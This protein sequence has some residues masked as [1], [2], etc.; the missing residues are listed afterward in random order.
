MWV[1]MGGLYIAIIVALFL[2]WM[3]EMDRRLPPREVATAETRE[4]S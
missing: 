4:P 1:P 2:G 3:R